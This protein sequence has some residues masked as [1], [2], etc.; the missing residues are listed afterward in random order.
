[1]DISICFADFPTEKIGET[2]R[3][4]RRFGIGYANLGALLM[5]TGHACDSDAAAPWLSAGA[6][7]DGPLSARW[8]RLHM[9]GAGGE[10]DAA[11]AGKLSRKLRG[12]CV[13]GW[14]VS[15]MN[16]GLGC[17]GASGSV[18]HTRRSS[19]LSSPMS[20]RSRSTAQ[21]FQ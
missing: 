5:T 12:W 1:M 9:A 20:S 11:E 18:D 2:T 7:R 4:V 17:T 10:E 19:R 21:P 8:G 13:V 3:A 6:R 14:P 15:Q 16:I